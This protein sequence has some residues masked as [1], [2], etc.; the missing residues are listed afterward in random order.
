MKAWFVALEKAFA[1]TDYVVLS[2]IEKIKRSQFNEC[3]IFNKK[4]V[5][6]LQREPLTARKGDD[7]VAK[8]AQK[9]VLTVNN[10]DDEPSIFYLF[11][12]HWPS[13]PRTEKDGSI[14]HLLGVH[15]RTQIDNVFDKSVPDTHVVLMG[16]YNEEPYAQT[17]HEQ[18]RCSRDVEL[19]K[20]KKRLLY[21]PLWKYMSN[22]DWDANCAGT[23]YYS[24]GDV[25]K[26]HTFDQIMI[27][28]SLLE[29]KRWNFQHERSLLFNL[30]DLISA[31]QNKN[32]NYDHL[33]I[34][35]FLKE[36]IHHE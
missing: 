6:I 29:G 15:L 5:S 2:G 24:S 26:W 27:S 12:S 32:S 33:P 25:T 8:L 4:T 14:R 35:C 30:P 22:M 23:Y 9:L 28:K 21:N 13:Q 7:G 20:K 1:N 11:V 31:V 19:V 36:K 16:D 18:L 10:G 3:F 34:F 17:I